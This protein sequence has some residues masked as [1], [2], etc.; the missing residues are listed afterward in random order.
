MFDLFGIKARREAREAERKAKEAEKLADVQEKKRLYQERK[1]KIQEWIK[2]YNKRMYNIA[3]NYNIELKAL[4]DKENSVCPKCGSK[5]VVNKVVRGKGEIHG[6]GSSSISGSFGGGLLGIGGHMYGSGKSN[7]DGEFDTYPVN[8]CKDCEHEWNIVE[9]ERK[10]TVDD[11]SH[12]S[13]ISPGYLYRRVEDFLEMKYDPTD[14]KD[15]CNSLEEK[16]EKFLKE[17]S[18]TYALR[19]YKKIPRYMV[20]VAMFEGF[21]E[22]SYTIERLPKIFNYH[23]NDDKYSYTMSNELWEIVKKIIGWEG[24]EE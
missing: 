15:D 12:Y 14:I 7:I 19:P 4:A 9:F 3:F 13:S 21:S 6:S 20:D 18:N 1:A 22:H 11:F 17:Y 16:R 5:N 10:E 23:E 2:D 8:R 24:T